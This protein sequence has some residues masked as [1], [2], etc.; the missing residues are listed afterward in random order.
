VYKPKEIVYTSPGG[1]N[2]DLELLY[3]TF[4]SVGRDLFWAFHQE[5]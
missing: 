1:G 4:S 5:C 3:Q 2:P